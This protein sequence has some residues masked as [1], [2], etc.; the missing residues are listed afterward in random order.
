MPRQFG[1]G[2]IVG[3]V[4]IKRGIGA[5]EEGGKAQEEGRLGA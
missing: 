2:E 4:E 1:R 5:A 3:R